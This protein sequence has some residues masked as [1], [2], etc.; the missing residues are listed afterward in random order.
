MHSAEFEDEELDEGE[1]VAAPDSSADDI[2]TTFDDDNDEEVE[3]ANI[4]STD[5]LIGDV[6]DSLERPARTKN[7]EAHRVPHTVS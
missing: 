4:R 1:I 5:E 2:D 6:L 7:M 3:F